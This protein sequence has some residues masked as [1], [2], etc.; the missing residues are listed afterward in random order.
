[1][2]VVFLAGFQLTV[3]PTRTAEWFSWTIDVPMTAFF[4]GAGVIHQQLEQE[5]VKLRFGKR[6]DALALDRILRGDHGKMR[7]Q[8]MRCPVQRDAPFLHRLQ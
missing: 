2:K 3:F 7:R 6:V 4:L 8:G 5:T 1:M